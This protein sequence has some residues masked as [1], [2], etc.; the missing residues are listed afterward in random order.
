MRIDLQIGGYRISLDEP[1]NH[2][3]LAWPMRPFDSFLA[4]PGTQSD[5][6]VTVT[7]AETGG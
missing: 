5:M 7:V 1:E 4:Q 6:D 3:R 2:P